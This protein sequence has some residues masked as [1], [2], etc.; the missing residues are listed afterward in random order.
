[1]ADYVS[2]VSNIDGTE[3]DRSQIQ[4]ISS[5]NP[6]EPGVYDVTYQ[7]T[8]ENERTGYTYLSVIVTN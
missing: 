2:K 1:M 3:A 7:Y 4:V 8:D 6:N 5:V